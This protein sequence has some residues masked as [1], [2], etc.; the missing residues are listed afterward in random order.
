MD[1]TF[2]KGAYIFTY[3]VNNPSDF[4][5]AVLDANN[6]VIAI[7]EKPEKPKSNQAII[8]IY[9]YDNSVI[10]KIQ[11]LKPSERGEY[12]IT[13]LNNLYIEEDSCM[14][15][16]I[17]GWWIDAGTPDRIEELESKLI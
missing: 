2:D 10:N 9:V 3:K 4:G 1:E 15:K 6:K 5:V 16:E 8:G 11:Q 7:E 14:S 12:E 17:D 13:D